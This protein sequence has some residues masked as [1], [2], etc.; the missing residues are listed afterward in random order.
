[1]EEKTYN[2]IVESLRLLKRSEQWLSIL[3]KTCAGIWPEEAGF[4]EFMEHAELKHADYV[5]KITELFQET[6]EEFIPIIEFNPLSVQMMIDSTKQDV[7]RMKNRELTKKQLLIIARDIENSLI[8]NKFYELIRSKNKEFLQLIKEIKQ[9][10]MVHKS[11]L[12]ERLKQLD[13]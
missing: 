11:Q 2:F 12:E 5:D 6:P 4:W 13:S 3:Y 9:Q 7:E 8:E 1:M 10:T